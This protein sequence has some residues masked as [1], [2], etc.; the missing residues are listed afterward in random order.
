MDTVPSTATVGSVLNQ[1]TGGASGLMLGYT[2][3]IREF[4]QDTTL[5]S[6]VTNETLQSIATTLKSLDSTLKLGFQG[7]G[8]DLMRTMSSQVALPEPNS[9]SNYRDVTPHALSK[10]DQNDL[11]SQVMSIMVNTQD[12][13][14]KTGE[15]AFYLRIITRDLSGIKGK[16]YAV[17]KP[18]EDLGAKKP[19]KR[20][21]SMVPGLFG[22]ILNFLGLDAEVAAITGFLMKFRGS[23]K[24]VGTAVKN[25][26]LKTKGIVPFVSGMIKGLGKRFPKIAATL[27]KMF[28]SPEFTKLAGRGKNFMKAIPIIGQVAAVMLAIWDASKALQDSKRITGKAKEFQTLGDKLNVGLSGIIAGFT[29]GLVDTKTVYKWV[30]YAEESIFSAMKSVF[31]MFPAPMKAAL[32]GMWDALF[33]RKTGILGGWLN[34]VEG[35]LDKLGNGEYLS[36]FYDALMMAP[37]TAMSMIQRALPKALEAVMKAPDLLSGLWDM[38]KSVMSAIKDWVIQ[39]VKDLISDP[40]GTLTKVN[41][42]IISAGS[43]INDIY[44]SITKP[45]AEAASMDTEAGIRGTRVRSVQTKTDEIN[46]LLKAG[47]KKEAQQAYKDLSSFVTGN[48]LSGDAQFQQQTAQNMQIAQQAIQTGKPQTAMIAAAPTQ[49]PG[50]QQTMT[51]SKERMDSEGQP[52]QITVSPI[53]NTPPPPATPAPIIRRLEGSLDR[54]LAFANLTGG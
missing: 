21:G 18:K 1:G 39:G 38:M 37:R 6:M 7:L 4:S 47:K 10:V 46:E 44:S 29:F 52:A 40:M 53:I 24:N 30:T 49:V 22:W 23:I 35:I 34:M 15:M 16:F 11:E 42:S 36:A 31:D 43:K 28:T 51:A 20:S 19:E 54:G 45:F 27:E 2:K 50:A 33:D 12:I 25:L 5:E 3:D 9:I 32:S 26:V 41:D 13:K 14:D 17:E 48:S 8:R